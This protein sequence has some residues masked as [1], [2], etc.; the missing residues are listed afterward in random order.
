MSDRNDS[1]RSW[2]SLVLD[3]SWDSRWDPERAADAV[4]EADGQA[5]AAK[6]NLERAVRC[7][8][9]ATEQYSDAIAWTASA[10]T[11]AAAL[12]GSEHGEK[13]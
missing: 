9:I 8:Q 12:P 1:R 2:R 13:P 11:F 10:R 5:L 7:V 6:A 3:R 4:L